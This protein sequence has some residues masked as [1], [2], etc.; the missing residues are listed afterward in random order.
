MEKNEKDDDVCE[1]CLYVGPP[2]KLKRQWVHYFPL[3]GKIIVCKQ[4]GLTS[5]LKCDTI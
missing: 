2:I 5:T 3:K 1:C 4:K